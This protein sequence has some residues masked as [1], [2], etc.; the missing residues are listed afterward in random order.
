[1]TNVTNLHGPHEYIG[2]TLSPVVGACVTLR[3]SGAGGP[4]TNTDF[5]CGVPVIHGFCSDKV[6]NSL[7]GKPVSTLSNNTSVVLHVTCSSVE[8]TTYMTV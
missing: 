7:P 3:K 8:E 2:E 5:G 6:G 4:T 1:M